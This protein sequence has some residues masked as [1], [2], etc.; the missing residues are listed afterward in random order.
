MSL[1]SNF[2]SAEFEGLVKPDDWIVLGLCLDHV[3]SYDR[4]H[5]LSLLSLNFWRLMF[6]SLLHQF[7]TEAPKMCVQSSFG[8]MHTSNEFD[9]I[10]W[11]FCLVKLT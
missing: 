10:G 3:D 1:L 11:V 4:Y 5:L 2:A 7:A 6:D 9:R 8:P